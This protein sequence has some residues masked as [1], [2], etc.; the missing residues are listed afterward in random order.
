MKEIL[1]KLQLLH[2][3]RF[4]KS[5]DEQKNEKKSKELETAITQL[6]ELPSSLPEDE[7]RYL[8][9]GC[10]AMFINPGLGTQQNYNQSGGSGNKQ[11]I[12]QTQHF[13][14][15]QLRL[16]TVLTWQLEYNS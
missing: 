3:S 8:Y 4:F 5:E 12:G 6:S 16:F 11:L 10:G 2:T 15:D 1:E 14:K 9:H 13:D 7:G